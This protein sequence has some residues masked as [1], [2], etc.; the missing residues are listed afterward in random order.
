V[1][2]TATSSPDSYAEFKLSIPA[3]KNLQLVA[4]EVGP[5]TLAKDKFSQTNTWVFQAVAPSEISLENISASWTNSDSKTAL[6]S[7][8][9][10]IATY[11]ALDHD[12]TPAEFPN[13][14]TASSNW[15]LPSILLFIVIGV[16]LFFLKRKAVVEAETSQ[17]AP[18]IDDLIET[19]SSGNI[20]EALCAHLLEEQP[21]TLSNTQK[22]AIERALYQPSFTAANLLEALTSNK[23]VQS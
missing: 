16:S 7:Q 10:V 23:E 13:E 4:R 15:L 18:T 6:P 8:K 20:P 17:S 21:N 19:L 22:Q 12:L 1:E 9:L 5:V 2:L 14:A 11:D 3:D